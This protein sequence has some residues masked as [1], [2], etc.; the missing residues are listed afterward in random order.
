MPPS[1]EQLYRTLGVSPRASDEELRAAYRRLVKRHHPDHNGGSVESARMFEAVQDA[2]AQLVKLRAGGAGSSGAATGRARSA[3]AAAGGRPGA[4]GAGGGVRGSAPGA[5]GGVRGSAPSADPH[6]ENKIA[7]MERELRAAQ[8]ARE[9]AQAAARKAAAD[10]ARQTADLRAQAAASGERPSDEDL[11]Y[12]TTED[13]LSKI[14]ADARSQL[15]G[16]FSEARDS[17]PAK[18]LGDLLD[19]ISSKLSGGDE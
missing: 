17:P 6:V 5:G 9:R 12:I 10:A 8:A 2:Y 11:G 7:D 19:D 16:L 15:A 14:I 18:R 4:P 3:G 13:S 1:V